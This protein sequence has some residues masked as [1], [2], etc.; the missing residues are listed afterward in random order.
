MNTRGVKVFDTYNFMKKNYGVTKEQLIDEVN[1]EI[2]NE[3]RGIS[4]TTN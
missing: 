4:E 2:L 3:V 1:S